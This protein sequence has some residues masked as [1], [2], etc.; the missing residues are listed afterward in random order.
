MR[1]LS[2]LSYLSFLFIG[3]VSA[4]SINYDD[5]GIFQL[6]AFGG[7]IIVFI[8]YILK[9]RAGSRSIRR[10]KLRVERPQLNISNS[11][12]DQGEYKCSTCG[13]DLQNKEDKTL[14][15]QAFH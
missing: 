4:M 1:K 2:Y 11:K 12:E 9:N 15:E 13:T 10:D 8:V 5:A 6:T 7:L 3:N 14:H